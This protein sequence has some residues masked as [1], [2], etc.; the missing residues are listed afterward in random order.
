MVTLRAGGAAGSVRPAVTP[1]HGTAAPNLERLAGTDIVAAM[2]RILPVAAS[3]LT[4]A[5]AAPQAPPAE[6]R[7]VP[8]RTSFAA[9][10][11]ATDVDAFCAAVAKLPHGDRIVLSSAGR[12]H[13]GRDQLLAKVSLPAD[14]APRLRV[15]AIGNIHAGE[16]EGKEALQVLLREFANGE[17]EDLLRHADLWFLPVYNADGNE[18][19]SRTNRA[20]QNGPPETGER[21]NAQGLDLNRDFVKVDAPETRNLLTLFRT[22]DPH[23]F[24]DLHTTNGSYHGYHVTY[25]TSLS[26]NVDPTIAA[27]SRT[28]L[29]AT[30]AAMLKEHGYATFDYGNFETHDWDGSGAPESAKGQR[31]WF[32]FDHRAR[33]GINYFGLRNRIAVLSEAYSYADF[34]TRIAATRAFVLCVL[35]AAVARRTEIAAAC[36]DADARLAAAPPV[37]FRFDTVFADPETMDVLVGEVDE[38][39]GVDGTPPR[40][41]RKGDGKPERM[42]VIRAFRARK[43]RPLPAAWAIEAPTADVRDRLTAHGVAFTLLAAATRVRAEAFAVAEKKKPK[44]PYQGHQELVL[45]GTWQA[46]A[47]CELAAGTLL[48]DAHQPLA[49]LAAVLLE[50]E[51]EDSLSS[52][53]FF[54][55]ATTDHYP[56]VRVLAP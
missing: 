21:A 42:P 25:A 37:D 16:V 54:E 15:L 45:G 53:N 52:W 31:G 20:G 41:V 6:P 49:R 26:P 14:G 5:L 33:Y 28:L 32:T 55:A 47:E 44:R 29:D 36:R 17:H 3:L 12:T 30:T 7:T 24:F 4:T 18:A 51:S 10:S 23:L 50:P 43:A 34:A 9:T 27:L 8:E 38:V 13:G 19:M 40:F 22:I 2:S 46:P 11:R 48:V 39:A 35:H 56:V 1:G